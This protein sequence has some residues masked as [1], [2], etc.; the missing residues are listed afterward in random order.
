MIRLGHY[1]DKKEK[2]QSHT[3]S[4]LDYNYFDNPYDVRGYGEDKEEALED[5]MKKFKYVMDELRELE[6]VL[7]ETSI[8]TDNI[9][10]VDWSGKEIKEEDKKKDTVWFAG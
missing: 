9:V 4:I 8:I 6:E 10:A 2:W 7:F 3:I 1:D 5:F